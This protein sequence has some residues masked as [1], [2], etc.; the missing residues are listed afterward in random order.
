MMMKKL[1]YLCLPILFF[2][3][4]KEKTSWD[5]NWKF[6]I[7]SD[8]LNLKN[9]VND[10]ILSVNGDGSYQ[11]VI[12]RDLLN[13]RI[14]SLIK[15]PDT[16]IAQ[17][18]ASS[19]P[20]LNLPA[21]TSFINQIEEHVFN[22]KDAQLKNV[23]LS[24]GSADITIKSPI[25]GKTILTLILPSVTK[26][27]V[28]FSKVVTAPAGTIANP[29]VTTDQLDLSG[30]SIDL[31]GQ[32]GNTFNT[33]QSQVLV[34]TDPAGSTVTITN[35]DSIAFYVK[36]KNLKPNYARG[37][38]GQI[39]YHDTTLVNLDIL[40][41]ISAGTIDIQNSNF[42]L[43]VSNGLKVTA[44]SK[45]TLIEGINASQNTVTL[46]H[47]Q[48]GIWNTLNQASGQWDH[49]QPSVFS[50][51]FNDLNSNISAFIENLPNKIRLGYSIEM[52]PLGNDSGGWN[53]YFSTS[54]IR[55]RL[56]A[57][58]PLAIGMNNL[59]YCDTLDLQ[60]KQNSDK[61]HLKSGK[62]MISAI[63]AYPFSAQLQVSV[64]NQNNQVIFT[65]VASS[66]IQGT[67]NL[68]N[69]NPLEKVK[70][71]IEI[72]LSETETAD[73]SQMKKVILKV[74]FDTPSGG[75]IASIYDNQFIFLQLFSNIE[76]T[77]KY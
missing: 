70:S 25:K 41:K 5:T 46:T 26:N 74:I 44:R 47:P 21:G 42:M 59:T 4:R 33:L 20:S 63:N 68:N 9:W 73:L 24:T 72:D 66:K 39:N 34:Q 67:N 28:A 7:L 40:S 58:M 22:V 45:F 13:L 65:K 76:L 64:L 3:C 17:K 50:W 60:V 8:T 16:T 29:S 43:E 69:T 37:Y 19:A 53:E 1:I 15:L 31:R 32:Y 61:T 71:D 12:N 77:N 27:G 23:I 18:V 54:R 52:N 38:F 55:L 14:D 48:L 62:L 49:L 6:P 51:I 10:S 11:L 2:S 35:S 56:T 57:N 75:Q 36:F 30:Y